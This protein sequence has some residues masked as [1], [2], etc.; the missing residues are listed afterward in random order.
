MIFPYLM[1]I[2]REIILHH[3]KQNFTKVDENPEF[4]ALDPELLE[5]GLEER[6]IPGSL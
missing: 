1:K 2:F 6:V 5:E 4:S 3:L